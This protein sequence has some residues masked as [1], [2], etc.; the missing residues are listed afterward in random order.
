MIPWVRI[1]SMTLL[2]AGYLAWAIEATDH[3]VR[4]GWCAL[5]SSSWVLTD[6][7]VFGWFEKG[8]S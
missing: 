2:Q 8:R 5:L 3:W 4:L 7:K 1:V 6:A